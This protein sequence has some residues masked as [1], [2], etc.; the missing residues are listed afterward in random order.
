[1]KATPSEPI[2]SATQPDSPPA[3]KAS[4]WR[5]V[6]MLGVLVVVCCALVYDWAIAPPR[7]KAAYDKLEKTALK[8][9]ELG[10]RP[11]AAKAGGPKETVSLE[12]GGMIYSEEVQEILGMTPSRTEKKELYTIE[13]YRWWGWIPRNQNFIAVVYIGDPER[14]HYSTHYANELPDDTKLPGQII[15]TPPP[16]DSAA[17]AGNAEGD[18][19]R[20]KV[21]AEEKKTKKNG[22]TPA[23][24]PVGEQ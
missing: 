18:G 2:T 14:R 6:M 15:A 20:P 8:R 10:F 17:G 24:A 4:P 22:G 23:R 19:G 7:V 16:V 9:N 12:G 5:L 3:A 21:V 11:R 1:M 13:Y